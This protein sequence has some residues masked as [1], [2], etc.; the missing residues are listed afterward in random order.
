M[1]LY[2]TMCIIDMKRRYLAHNINP[3]GKIKCFC[4]W[5]IERLLSSYE[6]GN[7]RNIG[8]YQ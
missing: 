2:N 8:A 3:A 7:K 5:H 4:L 6:S 1:Q